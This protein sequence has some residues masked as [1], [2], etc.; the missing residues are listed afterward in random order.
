VIPP[1]FRPSSF[2]AAIGSGRHRASHPTSRHCRRT[3][4]LRVQACCLA[5]AFAGVT[6]T[7]LAA[8]PGASAPIADALL[9]A[10]HDDANWILPAETYAG[11]RFTALT[12]IDKTNVGALSQAWRTSIADD[13]QQEAAPIIWNGTLYL[14][15]PHDGVLALDAHNGKLLWQK[16]YNP[17]YV[18]LYAVNRGVAMADG[19]V[20]IATQDPRPGEHRSR[21]IQDPL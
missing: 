14:S 10:E 20:F 11:N 12:Q 5:L 8:N 9:N 4:T 1:F 6:A 13:G 18:L 17:K 16:P 19:K 3:G 15:T 21:R 7:A 2:Q